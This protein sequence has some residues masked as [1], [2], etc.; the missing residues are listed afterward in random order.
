MRQSDGPAAENRW[1]SQNRYD[2]ISASEQEKILYPAPFCAIRLAGAFAGQRRWMSS[3][4]P[5]SADRSRAETS[6]RHCRELHERA[7]DRDISN[8]AEQR[9][10]DRDSRM[11]EKTE[12]THEYQTYVI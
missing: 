10:A 5:L 9:A 4:H 1:Q 8:I 12:V 2:K 6:E 3:G 7:S 11:N